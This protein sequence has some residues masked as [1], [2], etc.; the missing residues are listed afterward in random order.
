MRR[1]GLHTALRVVLPLAVAAALIGA[2]QIAAS[3]GAIAEALNIEP[4]FVPSPAEV[5]GALW[6]N[7]TLLLEN[8]WVTL[9]E[10]L[11][12]LGTGIVLGILLSV[13]MRFS[14]LLRDTFYP[15]AVA[16]QAV[17]IVVL[18]PILV[19]WF[20]YGV[21]PKVI[22]VAIACFFPILVAT[23]DGLRS[24]D[25]EAVKMMRTL[26]A[27]RWAI[28]RRVEAPTALPSFFSGAKIAVAIAPIV[29]LFA[30]LAG[31]NSGLMLVITQAN[32][33]FREDL[34]FAAALIL[35]VIGVLLVGLTA[36]AQRLVVTWR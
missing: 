31:A 32:N 4:V 13:A 2:W 29:A 6:D 23:L 30:E 36:L 28:F 5:A 1:P 25:P 14:W 9:R 10:I 19:V 35:A 21:W 33:N 18:A 20:N 34:V 3:N 17:P 24:V 8:A 12:G 11:I 16:L 22:I 27:S 7:R 26:D 15:I